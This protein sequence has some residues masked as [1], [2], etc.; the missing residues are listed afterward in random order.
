MSAFLPKEGI[1]YFSV[2]KCA[3]STL[4]HFFFEA[5]N[6]RAFT[7]FQVS[8]KRVSVH[9]LYKCTSFE[10]QSSLARGQ[11]WKF[12]VVRDPVSRVVS[13]Y[14]NRIVH[15]AQLENPRFHAANQDG[16]LSASPTLD[17]FVDKLELYRE[18]SKVVADHVKPLSH[19]LGRDPDY[20]DRIFALGE[21]DELH[22]E[23]AKRFGRDIPGFR[24]VQATRSKLGASELSPGGREKLEALYEE[25]YRLFGVKF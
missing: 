11:D 18:R 19:F 24:R 6:G 15:H 21:L 17:E 10:A 4:K 3:S 13:A 1:C 9:G 14:N 22:A 23:L 5:E 2:P 16:E 8:G 12:A 20:F 7:A 25:D